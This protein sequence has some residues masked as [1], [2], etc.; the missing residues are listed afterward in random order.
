MDTKTVRIEMESMKDIG[1]N[2]LTGE[3]CAI[4]MRLL[5]ELS[6][7]AMKLYLDFTG[8]QIDLESIP[9]NQYNNRSYYS[10]F[11]TWDTMRDLLIM[12]H[13]NLGYQV[14]LMIGKISDQVRTMNYIFC[15]NNYEELRDYAEK[16]T[17]FY[18]CKRFFLHF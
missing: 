11:L 8:I 4:S 6:S 13:V 15:A 17:K 1:I 5:C 10:C 2:I 14:A 18:E 9:H 3:A 12:H 16:H 7:E